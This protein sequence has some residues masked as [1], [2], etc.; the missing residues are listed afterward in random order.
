MKR[1]TF[2]LTALLTLT[3]LLPMQATAHQ[4]HQRHQGGVERLFPSPRHV[5][6]LRDEL[7]LSQDQQTRIRALVEEQRSAHQAQRQTLQ[8]A[9]A[10]LREQV[11]SGA[12]AATIRGAFDQVL[13]LENELKRQRLELGLSLR[14]VLTPEQRTQLAEKAAERRQKVQKRRELR[15]QRTAP[16][17]N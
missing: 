3:F 16:A 13:E 6:A 8:Q 11:Q 5:M 15:R 4:R 14:Q 1:L 2:A 17:A 12:N 10:S 7:N 9:R